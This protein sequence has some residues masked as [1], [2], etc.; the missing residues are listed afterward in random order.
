M[1][2]NMVDGR[3]ED[4]QPSWE[5]NSGINLRLNFKLSFLMQLVAVTGSGDFSLVM[6]LSAQATANVP[7]RLHFYRNVMDAD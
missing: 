1:H 7:V 6:L 4:F 5:T 2:G 3:A